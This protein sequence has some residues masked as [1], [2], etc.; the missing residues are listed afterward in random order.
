MR[1]KTLSY[2]PPRM[3]VANENRTNPRL[4]GAEMGT[5]RSGDVILHRAP[6]SVDYS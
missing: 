2:F 4:L 6:N 5:L 1:S 3:D